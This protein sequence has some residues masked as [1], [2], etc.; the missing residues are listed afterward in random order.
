MRRRRRALLLE[1]IL[2]R[3]AGVVGAH[4]DRRGRFFF[5]GHAN[6][7]ERAIV[8]RVF[9]GDSLFDGLHALKTASGI[10]I[11]ALLAGVEFEG[12]LGTETGGRDGLQHGAALRAAGDGA[13][14]RHVHGLWTHAVVASRRGQRGRLFA[15]L[16]FREI[17]A[18]LLF[19]VAVLVSM[20]T[21]FGHGTSEHV[22]V[23]SRQRRFKASL[24]SF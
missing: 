21:V 15:G 20:L 18:R 7:V 3:L 12:A 9:F 16:L 10:E 14:A 1:Q 11:H 13:S 17:T 23:L 24:N 22:G 19:A 5:A 8:A 2:E 6:F 4:A